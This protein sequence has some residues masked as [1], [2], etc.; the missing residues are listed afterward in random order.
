M[1]R[2]RN[3]LAAF[4]AVL[5]AAWVLAA[6]ARAESLVLT[7]PD[8]RIA[9][10]ISDAGGEASYEVAFEGRPVIARSRLGLLFAAHHGFERD[11]AITAA[12]RASRDD[13]W[14]QPWGERRQVRDRHNELA[15]TFS[16]TTGP[17]R[18]MVVRF[19]AFDDGIGFRYELGAQAALASE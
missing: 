13:T 18:S 17:A 10:T 15:V 8:G 3:I 5:W 9:I 7:S 6:P 1:R 16:A 4:A 2:Y 14:E 19:R 11:L 12:A